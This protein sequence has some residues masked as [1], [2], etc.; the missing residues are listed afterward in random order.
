MGPALLKYA[1]PL[2]ITALLAAAVPAAW[3]QD[4]DV[5]GLSLEQLANVEVTS[6]SRRAEPVSRAPAAV[7]VITAEDIRRSSFGTLPDVLRLSSDKDQQVIKGST[8]E[9]IVDLIDF[10]PLLGD[11]E[12][13]ILGQGVSMPMRIRFDE[14]GNQ[15]RPKNMNIGFSKSWKNQNMDRDQ[16]DTIVGRWRTTGREKSEDRF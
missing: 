14:L 16:L 9:G 2:G 10:L 3:A 13:L 5:T 11:R 6:V 15:K 7:F 12:A 1:I 8:Y 4:T